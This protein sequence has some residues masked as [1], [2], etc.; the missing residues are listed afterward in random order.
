MITIK[1]KVKILYK[2]FEANLKENNNILD[3]YTNQNCKKFFHVVAC[4]KKLNI[5][6]GS[7]N[8]G[9]NW[10][11]FPVQRFHAGVGFC[12]EQTNKQI[13]LQITLNNQNIVSKEANYKKF[14]SYML[15]KRQSLLEADGMM[16]F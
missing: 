11:N 8:P 7:K 16:L 1:G 9:K 2:E 12:Y 13:F 5:A 14:R 4:R 15:R 10:L 3:D 6:I